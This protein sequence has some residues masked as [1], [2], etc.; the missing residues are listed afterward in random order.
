M[1]GLHT[2]R[3]QYLAHDF[4]RDALRKVIDGQ[5]GAEKLR[6][7]SRRLHFEFRALQ[8]SVKN[9]YRARDVQTKP[10]GIVLRGAKGVPAEQ[11]QFRGSALVAQ[12]QLEGLSS[13][14]EKKSW[15]SMYA[16]VL[17]LPSLCAAAAKGM[18]RVLSS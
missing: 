12:E 9:R 15:P 4:L 3:A 18:R 8:L 11:G 14:D 13:P 6:V 16:V 2:G 17:N 7:G 1:D 5:Y 10:R